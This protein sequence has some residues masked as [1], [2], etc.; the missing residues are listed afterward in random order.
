MNKHSLVAFAVVASLMIAQ[1]EARADESS[2]ETTHSSAPSTNA[3]LPTATTWY[4]HQVLAADLASVGFIVAGA[5]ADQPSVAWIGL[6]G[7]ALGGPAVHLVHDRPGTALGSLGLRL[8]LPVLGAVVGHTA[9][10]TCRERPDSRSLLGDCF[11]HGFAEAAAGSMI[12]MGVASALDIGVLSH[13]ETKPRR[14]QE[15]PRVASF[16]PSV[17]PRAGSASLNLAGVF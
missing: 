6:G 16:A 7:L 1:S 3:A 11:L 5:A 12:G 8:G 13:E 15:G 2:A 10:G 9:A 4:G 17:D 14:F